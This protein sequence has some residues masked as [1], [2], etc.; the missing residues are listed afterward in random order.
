VFKVSSSLE[1]VDLGQK[2]E[3]REGVGGFKKYERKERWFYFSP[4]DNWRCRLS[5]WP[6]SLPSVVIKHFPAFTSPRNVQFP[7]FEWEKLVFLIYWIFREVVREFFPRLERVLF[8][9]PFNPS[10]VGGK[11]PYL[12]RN[13]STRLFKI[14]GSKFRLPLKI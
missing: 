5:M 13:I 6:E 9:R 14:L 8:S 11:N 10:C 3:R 4:C 7:S 12:V 2:R 1:N